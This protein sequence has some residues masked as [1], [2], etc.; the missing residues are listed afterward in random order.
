V[1]DDDSEI[2]GATRLYRRLHP[3]QIVYDANEGV[4]RA[5]SGAFKDKRLSVNLGNELDRINEP[6]DFALRNRPQHSLGWLTAE[7]VRSEEQMIESTPTEEDPTHG[8][9]VGDK[10]GSR[11]ERFAKT[12][13]IDI[14]RREFLKPEVRERLP[15]E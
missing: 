8:E 1:T 14:I 9:V 11:R 7:F 4:V 12:I 6:P 5:S 13:E 15:D 3:T 10:P 2:P